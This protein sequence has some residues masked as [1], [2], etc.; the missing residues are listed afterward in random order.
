MLAGVR[1]QCLVI[2]RTADM[3][4]GDL[5]DTQQVGGSNNQSTFQ[6]EKAAYRI[7]LFMRISSFLSPGTLIAYIRTTTLQA[8]GERIEQRR[9]VP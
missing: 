1:K 4:Y 6:I 7:G 2:S 8:I 3:G 5:Y 9:N